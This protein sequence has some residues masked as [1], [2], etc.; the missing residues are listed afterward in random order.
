MSNIDITTLLPRDMPDGRMLLDEGRTIGQSVTVGTS[1]LCQTHGVRSEVEYKKKM[2]E[3]GR[4][5]TSM[6]IGMKTW[7]E[8]EAALEKIHTM[9]EDRGFRIDRYQMQLDRRMGLPKEFWNRAAKETGPMLE[10]ENDWRATAHTVPIQPQLGDMMI[11]SPASVHNAIQALQV[12][13]NYIGNMSQ[14]NW[15]YPAWPGDDVEQMAEMVKALGLMASKVDDG[16][17]MQSYLEDGY[18]AQFKDYCSYIGWALFERYIIHEVI[19]G[20]LSI[21]YGGL[22]HN[23]VSKTAVILALEKIK[24]EGTYNSFYHCNTTAYSPEIDE[25]FAVLSVDDLYLMLAQLKTKS[26]AATLSIPVTEALRIPTWEEIVQVQTVAHRVANDAERLMESIN[27]PYIEALSDRMIEGGRRFY[28]NLLQGLEDLGVDMQ[29]P[30]KILLAVRRLGAPEIEN[31]YGVGELPKSDTDLYEPIVATDTFE[32]F[33]RRRARV[34]STFASCEVPKAETVKL[35]IGSTDI[36]EYAMFLLVEALTSLGVEPII[37]GTSVDPDEF[38]DLALEAGADAILVST[39]NGMA[40]TYARQLQKEVQDRSMNI[41]IAM[42]GTLNQD[43][44]DEPAPIDVKD[45]LVDLGIRVCTDVTDVLA[46]VREA[47]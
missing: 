42:G 14:F 41:P 34:K 5:M 9:A 46:I 3:S 15:K 24:P 38:A 26:G 11:G 32:D 1:L 4:L 33:V 2:V 27:W 8:T 13:V 25:N 10:T 31:R 18:P 16:A 17:M 23:P 30:L 21:A 37:A 20:R 39:H 12:G 40:L 45:D 6:N 19:G 28:E 36:H 47:A 43:I 7:A 35:V 44:E 29:D 22:T